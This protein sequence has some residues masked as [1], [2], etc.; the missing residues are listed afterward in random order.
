[1]KRHL[2]LSFSIACFL[3]FFFSHYSLAASF[4]CPTAGSCVNEIAHLLFFGAMIFFIYE[5]RLVGLGKFRGFR[6]LLWA[7]A[8]LA[9]WNL[10]TF[11]GHLAACTITRPITLG[12]GW[13]LRLLIYD[14]STWTVFITRINNFI[15]LVPAFYLFYRGIKAL[16][17][18]PRAEHR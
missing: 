11:V 17:Q 8:L 10:D 6:Y 4:N 15:L 5:I 16:A 3:L 2:T 1:M 9:L 7:W 14:F 18:I 13:Y 12:E